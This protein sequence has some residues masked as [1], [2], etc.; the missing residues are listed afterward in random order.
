MGGRGNPVR[1]GEHVNDFVERITP[2]VVRHADGI[3]LGMFYG[4]T[5]PLGLLRAGV[6]VLKSACV[7]RVSGVA[8]QL[9]DGAHMSRISTDSPL[10]YGWCHSLENLPY[11]AM[12][13]CFVGI[14]SYRG[15]VPRMT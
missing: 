11:S 5:P 3:T 13:S 4:P 6:L 8:E 15:L 2:P 10:L 9:C 7:W 14:H 1:I 12:R